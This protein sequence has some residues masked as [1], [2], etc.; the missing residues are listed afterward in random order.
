MM[1]FIHT[2]SPYGKMSLTLLVIGLIILSFALRSAYV[3][4]TKKPQNGK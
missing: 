1:D 2:L 3:V 4:A